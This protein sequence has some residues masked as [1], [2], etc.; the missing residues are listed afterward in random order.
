M[1]LR[2][3]YRGTNKEDLVLSLYP[4]AHQLMYDQ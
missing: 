2:S 1:V 4:V 3:L